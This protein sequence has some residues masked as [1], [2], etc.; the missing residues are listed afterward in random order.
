MEKA[1]GKTNYDPKLVCFTC[2][3]GWGYLNSSGYAKM[4]EHMIPVLCSGKVDTTHIME[5]FR[6]GADGVLILGCPDGDC[7][8][9]NGNYQAR[10]RVL[11]MRRALRAFGIEPE[12]LMIKLDMDPEGATVSP[13]IEKM[14]EQLSRLGPLSSI[15]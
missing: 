8:F 12:R 6:K 5:A 15:V 3:F 10:K 2:G 4:L 13:L 7:H 1:K 9:Q 14:R 11:L